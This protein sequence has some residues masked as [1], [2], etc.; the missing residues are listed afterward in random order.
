MATRE[1]IHHMLDGAS[2]FILA[3][4]GALPDETTPAELR[5]E[6][7]GALP[8]IAKVQRAL[9]ELFPEI[10]SG[11]YTPADKA[12]AYQQL[13]EHRERA[14]AAERAGDVAGARQI[15]EDYLALPSPPTH[16]ALAALE[17]WRLVN[18]TTDDTLPDEPASTGRLPLVPA[19]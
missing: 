14:L 5:S 11:P 17:L 4:V 7:Y 2:H 16:H 12:A 3:A 10:R 6:L 8:R 9:R 15:L 13:I 18:A 1:S 19:E